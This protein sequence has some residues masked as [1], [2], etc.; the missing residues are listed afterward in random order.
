MCL[1]CLQRSCSQSMVRG[2][3]GFS[4]SFQDVHRV[5]HNYFHNS[6][7][8][9]PFSLVAICTHGTKELCCQIVPVIFVFFTTLIHSYKTRPFSVS[10]SFIKQSKPLTL[11]NLDYL[12]YVFVIFCD[13]MEST[14]STS[15]YRSTMVVLRESTC[16]DC[17]SY[18]FNKPLFHRIVFLL[19]RKINR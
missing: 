19:E 7:E 5:L 3:Q 14:P 17:L 1:H 9:L 13:E 11:L 16:V 8:L 12:V 4:R 18:K 15:A 6:S 10:M 2:Y